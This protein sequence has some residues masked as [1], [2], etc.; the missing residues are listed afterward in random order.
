MA[1]LIVASALASLGIAEAHT[2]CAFD[3]LPRLALRLNESAF[4]GRF[5]RNSNAGN[6][7]F[8]DTRFK[9]KLGGNTL[10]RDCI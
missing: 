5:R 1:L 10:L 7:D 6:Q 3:Q 4:V 2:G 8:G 9:V